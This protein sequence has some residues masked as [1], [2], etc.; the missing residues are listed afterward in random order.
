MKASKFSEAQIAFV[1]KQ[2]ED[3]TP[4]GEV[5][6]KAGI[7]DA[8]LLQLAQKICRSDAVRD[9]AIAAARGGERQ[10]EADCCR[11]VAGQGDASGR[12]V[13]KA[14][15]PARKRKLVDTIKADWKVSIRRAC[16]V[17]KIDRSLYVYKSTRGEQAELKLK[18][19]DICQTRVRYGYRRVHVLLKRDGWPVNPKRIYRL[20]KEMDLQLRTR[21][22]S[23][24]SRRSCE[25]T[26]RSRPI[27]ITS[28]RWISF[29]TSWPPGARSGC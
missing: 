10:A 16:S 21:F 19:K 22:P 9:E 6:R 26:G 18:I 29:M 1:V 23:V 11:P 5:C 13:K 2:A 25:P 7:S 28:G 20:Y 12:A 14:L 15:K 27:P 17:L 24:G 8:T 3:G 4:I